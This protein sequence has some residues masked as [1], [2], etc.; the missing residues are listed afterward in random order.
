MRGEDLVEWVELL[1]L[2]FSLWCICLTHGLLRYRGLLKGITINIAA[3]RLQHTSITTEGQ[4]ESAVAKD[5]VQLI[6]LWPQLRLGCPAGLHQLIEPVWAVVRP[7]E[8]LV[9]PNGLS[10]LIV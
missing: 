10:D 3:E 8:N 4:A 2:E 9:P 7:V 1:T 6:K 5:L